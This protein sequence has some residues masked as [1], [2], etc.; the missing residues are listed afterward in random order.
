MGASPGNRRGD[1]VWLDHLFGSLWYDGSWQ[2]WAVSLV[3]SVTTVS[4]FDR[5]DKQK[6]EVAAGGL[7]CLRSLAWQGLLGRSPGSRGFVTAEASKQHIHVQRGRENAPKL[8]F[9]GTTRENVVFECCEFGD[10]CCG[11]DELQHYPCCAGVRWA[12]FGRRGGEA[13]RDQNENPLNCVTDHLLSS[14]LH[15]Y[16]YT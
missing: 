7:C 15:V 10:G 9:G 1:G 16:L 14:P 11:G 4:V 3:R 12:A 2:C 6:A 5:V 8:A 13:Y